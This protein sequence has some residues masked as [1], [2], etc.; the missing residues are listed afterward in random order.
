MIETLSPSG[1][2]DEL[3]LDAFQAQ[4]EAFAGDTELVL[5]FTAVTFCG[6]GCIRLLIETANRLRDGG[7]SLIIRNAQSIVRR[8]FQ[9][10]AVDFLLEPEPSDG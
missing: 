8:A 6:S 1:D 9:V 2:L 7:G 5:D 3:V 4:L 10:G